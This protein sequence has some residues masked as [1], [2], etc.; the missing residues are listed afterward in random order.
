MNMENVRKLLLLLFNLMDDEN[1][2]D[3]DVSILHN[4]VQ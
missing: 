3:H 1:E 4:T 2:A